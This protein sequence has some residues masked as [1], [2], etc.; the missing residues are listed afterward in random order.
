M[1]LL[2]DG[3]IAAL[4]EIGLVTLLFFVISAIVRPRGRG[5]LDAVAVIPCHSGDGAKLEQTVH[6][7]TRSRWECGG[8]RRIV[9]LDHG[10]DED[11]RKVASLLCHDNIDVTI[12]NHTSLLDE[13]E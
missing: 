7:L 8:F 1:Q 9:I 6:T 10:M 11:T 4:A 2:E 5:T 13:L 3:I 12:W